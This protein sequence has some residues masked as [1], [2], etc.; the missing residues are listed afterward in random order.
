[1]REGDM[2]MRIS[3]STIIAL[4]L[5]ALAAPARAEILRLSCEYESGAFHGERL[6][7]VV[8]FDSS[9]IVWSER[10]HDFGRER[11]QITD[12]FISIPWNSTYSAHGRRIDRT[13]GVVS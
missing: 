1:M 2:S 7:V 5:L 11:A 10:G 8:D 9:T 12:Q 4:S 13:T 3:L 6:S